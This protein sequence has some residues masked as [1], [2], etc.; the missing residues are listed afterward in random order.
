MDMR[1][2]AKRMTARERRAL[3]DKPII[4]MNYRICHSL[5]RWAGTIVN[6]NFGEG[7]VKARAGSKPKY[8]DG[9]GGF[10]T[11]GAYEGLDGLVNGPWNG[12]MDLGY[13]S[14][15]DSSNYTEDYALWERIVD[16]DPKL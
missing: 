11:Q 5:K 15:F 1:A 8:S 10:G 6:D 7:L 4:I 12:A 9:P 3:L 2:K 14:K 13:A 16:N